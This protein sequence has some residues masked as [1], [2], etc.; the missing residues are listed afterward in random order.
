MNFDFRQLT[1]P[2]LSGCMRSPRGLIEVLKYHHTL[3]TLIIVI[4][5]AEFT[6]ADLYDAVNNIQPTPCQAV[7]IDLKY[8]IHS[9]SCSQYFPSQN[10][11]EVVESTHTCT[12]SENE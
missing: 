10:S 9:S 1:T 12:R 8:T 6:S 2:S 3:I 5:L 7:K 11:C 4:P